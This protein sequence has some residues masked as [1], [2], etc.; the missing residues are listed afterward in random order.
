MDLRRLVLMRWQISWIEG[1]RA[2]SS[3]VPFLSAQRIVS[4]RSAVCQHANGNNPSSLKSSRSWTV[5]DGT[6]ANERDPLFGRRAMLSMLWLLL[7]CVVLCGCRVEVRKQVGGKPILVATT[8]MIADIAR[9]LVG[10]EFQIV[11]LMGDGVDPHLYKPTR[12]DLVQLIRADVV[13]YNGLMLEGKMQSVLNRLGEAERVYAVC[14]ELPVQILIGEDDHHPDPHVWMDVTLWRSAT[15]R[16]SDAICL[17]YPEWAERV[18]RREDALVAELSELHMYGQAAMRSIP[19]SQRIL[20]TSHDAFQYFGRAYGLEIQAIQGISTESEAGLQRINEVVDLIVD[21]KLPA[22]FIESSV[23]RD[24][25]DAV[26]Q[27]AAAR[28]HQVSIG[29][30]L[31]SDALGSTGS[32]EGTYIGMLDHNFTTV[33]RALGGTVPSRGWKDRLSEQPLP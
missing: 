10:E 24:T 19:A 12:D 18:Q 11:Q 30:E 17:A 9:R 16:M 27:G 5:G 1:L 28:G 22:V 13:L 14:D 15:Q 7:P 23:P 31:Y 32:Y 2:V 33:A 25:I 26:V 8:G 21:R 4:Q 6:V 3:N 20:I 29:G